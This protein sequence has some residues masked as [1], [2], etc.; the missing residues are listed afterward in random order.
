L[1]FC[2]YELMILSCV[3]SKV[4]MQVKIVSIFLPWREKGCTYAHSNESVSN[5]CK[6]SRNS[7]LPESHGINLLRDLIPQASNPPFSLMVFS[8]ARLKSLTF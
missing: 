8:E 1:G 6:P 2:H 3:Y 4:L 5:Q 7:Q